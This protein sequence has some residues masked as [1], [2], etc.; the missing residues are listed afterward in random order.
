VCTSRRQVDVTLPRQY[1]NRRAF[2]AWVAGRER[3]LPVRNGKVHISFA[4]I[5]APT[6]FGRVVAAVI[7]V[8]GKP[9]AARLYAICTKTD[10]VGQINVPPGPL[11]Q[12]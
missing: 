1:R 8:R 11:P 3:I 12:L 6:R 9:V 4:G 10:G 2:R 7:W 5:Q